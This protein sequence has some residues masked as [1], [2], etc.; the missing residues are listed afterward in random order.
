MELEKAIRYVMS[1]QRDK[2]GEKN[3]LL[4]VAIFTVCEAARKH[5]ERD[6]PLPD[7]TVA[8]RVTF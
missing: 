3:L 5:H 6:K 1:L 8:R 4:N 7:V 2:T